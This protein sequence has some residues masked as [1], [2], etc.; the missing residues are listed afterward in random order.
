[1]SHISAVMQAHMLI[2][3]LASAH[4]RSL[5]LSLSLCVS[6]YLS[7]SSQN[8]FKVSFYWSSVPLSELH[9]NKHT[10]MHAVGTFHKTID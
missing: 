8:W 2:Q 9:T 5:S 6:F 4:A 10:Q 1:M 7:E 3:R